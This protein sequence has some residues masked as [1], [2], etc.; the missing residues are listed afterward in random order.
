MA[1]GI[2]AVLDDIAMLADDVAI[3]SK[4]AGT[5]TA[6]ILGDDVAVNASKAT[7]FHQ[8]RELKVIWEI[9]KGSL[10][11]KLIIVPIALILSTFA[12]WVVTIALVLGG[13]YLL[14]EGGEK[15]EEYLHIRFGN[16]EEHKAELRASTPNNVLEVEKKKIKAAILT[17]FILSIEIVII[18]LSSVMNEPLL[19]QIF[20]TSLIAFGATFGVYGFVAL[21][22]RMDN[23]GFWLE[24]KGQISLGN[25]FIQAMPVVIRTLTV[26]GTIAMILVGGGIMLHNLHIVHDLV[27]FADGIPSMITEF[28]VGLVF[29]FI[30]L[31]VVDTFEWA[32]EK[33]G[34]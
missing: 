6:A 5:H 23:L 2:V 32:K 8:S 34:K 27:H 14:F 13:F 31:K 11:N 24:D 18:A 28:G 4:T 29:A 15:I 3:A 20:T 7:G 22:V 26:I 9:T 1:T 10:K 25:F 12:P 21:I 19:V 30:T 33:I 17:D 16:G